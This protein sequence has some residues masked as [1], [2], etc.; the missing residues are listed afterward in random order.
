MFGLET[1]VFAYTVDYNAHSIVPERAP[2]VLTQKIVKEDVHQKIENLI[3]GNILKNETSAIIKSENINLTF[4]FK[5]DKSK[6]LSHKSNIKALED[7]DFEKV[8]M[9]TVDGYA[10]H[11][12]STKYNLKLSDNRAKAIIELIKK[13]G[14]KGEF[15]ENNHGEDC[16][17]EN[18]AE[19]SKKDK[20]RLCQ[21]VDI[22][23]IF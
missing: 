19:L 9:I 8:T 13:H 10:S 7:I 4:Y 3:Q 20:G 5:F 12:G 11:P 16:S 17:L 21:K 23:I 1:L 18:Q 15:T 22:Q 6:P 14:Y 2:T